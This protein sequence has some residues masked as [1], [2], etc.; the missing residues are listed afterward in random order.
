MYIIEIVTTLVVFIMGFFLS[1]IEGEAHI[2]WWKNMPI[3]YTIYAGCCLIR[4]ARLWF[5]VVR[6]M[7]Q[8]T[9][10]FNAIHNMPPFFINILGMFS[11]TTVLF[12]Q[13]GVHAFGGLVNSNTDL[14]YAELSGGGDGNFYTR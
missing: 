8:I 3:C 4:V 9:A 11:I 2:E 1:N 7:P 10:V 5:G 6:K 14:I 13:I 12:A